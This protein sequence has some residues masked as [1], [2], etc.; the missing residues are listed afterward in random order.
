MNG[1]V[2]IRAVGYSG[3][4]VTVIG[5]SVCSRGYRVGWMWCQPTR[6]TRTRVVGADNNNTALKVLGTRQVEIMVGTTPFI[7]LCH[8]ITFS[9]LG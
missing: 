1:V 2:S 4:Q 3:A 7:F 8:A 6:T 9:S 5:Q